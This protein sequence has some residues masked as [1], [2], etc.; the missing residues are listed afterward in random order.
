MTAIVYDFSEIGT[1]GGDRGVTSGTDALDSAVASGAAASIKAGQLCSYANGFWSVVADG[2]CNADGQYGLALST[3]TDTAADDGL[4]QVARV[5]GGA[6]KLRGAPTT[7]GNLAVGILGDKVTLDVAAGVMT[8]DENDAN[9][10]LL[11]TNYDTTNGTID[12]LLPY[13]VEA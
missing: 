4:V 2:G 12:F 11:I 3:S 7:S 13:S 1:E 6:L 10:V 8:V 5:K 9:G